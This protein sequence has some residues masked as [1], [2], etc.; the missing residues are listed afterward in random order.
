MLGA[1]SLPHCQLSSSSN[2]MCWPCGVGRPR[3]R[4]RWR[5]LTAASPSSSKLHSRGLQKGI[6]T[7]AS[8]AGSAKS[9][10][11]DSYF[12]K[13]CNSVRQAPFQS[14]QGS[15]DVRANGRGQATQRA[16]D[17]TAAAAQA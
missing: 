3:R 14:H 2:L 1:L 7:L 10:R 11:S 12:F 13:L 6:G 4:R 16:V 8:Y 15:P 9:C 5:G 17:A